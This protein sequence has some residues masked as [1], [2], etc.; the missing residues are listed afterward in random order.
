[1]TYSR[2]LSIKA[3][4]GTFYLLHW[5]KNKEKKKPREKLE[6][7]TWM[8]SLWR[9]SC[10]A[11]V[12]LGKASQN[13]YKFSSWNRQILPQVRKFTAYCRISIV[14][15]ENDLFGTGGQQ[16]TYTELERLLQ[17][18]LPWSRRCLSLIRFFLHFFSFSAA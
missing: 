7:T 3:K 14:E 4:I 11:F 5:K 17:I 8:N 13:S 12:K 16:R 18:Q 2:H 15:I 10:S 1:M 6:S 9:R